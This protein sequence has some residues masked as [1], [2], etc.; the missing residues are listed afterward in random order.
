MLEGRIPSVGTVGDALDNALCETTIGLFEQAH[1]DFLEAWEGPI[2]GHRKLCRALP[3]VTSPREFRAECATATR[4]WRILATF[5]RV[6]SCLTGS[7]VE[8]EAVAFLAL[9]KENSDD[10]P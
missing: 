1:S 5:E 7:L 6:R 2:A 4:I 10:S 8:T 3:T 9:E